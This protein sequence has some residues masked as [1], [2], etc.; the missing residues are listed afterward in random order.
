MA[1]SIHDFHD[2]PRNADIRIWINGA[3]KPRAEAVVSVFDSGFVLGDGV[4]EGLR[5]VD[6]HPAFLDAHLDRL[7][8]GARAIA[9]DIGLDRARLTRAIYDT[10]A[11]NA[12]RDGVHL[13]LMVTRGVKRTPYQDP[14]VTIGPATIVIIPEHKTAK[15]ETLETG[16]K[17]F[18]VHVRRGYPDVQD[19]KLNSHSKLNCITACIQATEAGADEALMLD[20]HGFVATCNST[21]FF[22]VRKGEVWTSSGDYCLGGITRANVLRAC[23]EA[24]I[25]AFEKNFSL[26][27][28]YGADEAFV[29]GTFAGVVPV[30][31]ID[32][33][34]MGDGTP[35]PMVARL[36]DLYRDLVARDIAFRAGERLA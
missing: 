10:L 12:M 14:R 29:T 8:E 17:L 34:V 31:Q 7:Y 5:V 18:T 35:G 16:L 9:L 15:P 23:H 4:W 1:T 32:G 28:V 3:L 21:H 33:R 26:T 11:A 25:P 13:R 2:D 6:G 19:P 36:Q 27:E 24:G 20:P 30:R 22:I